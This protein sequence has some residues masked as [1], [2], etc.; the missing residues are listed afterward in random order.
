MSA[1]A[2][3]VKDKRS[4]ARRVGKD[5]RNNCGRKNFYHSYEVTAAMRRLG[6]LPNWDCW[7]LSL[8]VSPHDFDVYHSVR[9][10]SCDYAGMHAAMRNSVEQEG[11]ETG[12]PGNATDSGNSGDGHERQHNGPAHHHH[13]NDLSG[14]AHHQAGDGAWSVLDLFDFQ[15]W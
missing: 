6:Y 4:L 15:D 3:S 10:E 2:I 8:Y 12:A 11:L 14:G 5:L 9:G 13:G 1:C 7:A